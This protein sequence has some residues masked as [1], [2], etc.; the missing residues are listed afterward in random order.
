M[1]YSKYIDNYSFLNKAQRLFWNIIYASFFRPFA[2]PLFHGWRNFILKIF[3][4]KIG[5]GS[6]IHASVKI[7][8]P[9][10]LEVGKRTC[11]GPKVIC[12]NPGKII[13]G[14]KVTISQYSY[15]CTATHNYKSKLHSLYWKDI[16]IDDFSWVAADSFIGPG[17]TIG[18]GAVV[19]ARSAVFKNV[20]AWTIVGGNPSKFIK[21]R[22]FDD[23]K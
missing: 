15:L 10:N 8:A 9:W 5:E 23:E 1:E 22:Q 3:G 19:G 12:Y 2:L 6:I 14:N 18:Q 7:W 17:V 21:K 16:K 11:I 13:L 4:A 20:E